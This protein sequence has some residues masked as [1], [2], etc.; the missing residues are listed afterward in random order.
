[1]MGELARALK[2]PDATIAASPVTPERL[3]ELLGLIEKRHDQRRDRQGRVR[4]DVRVR[5][6][7]RARSSRAEGLT[8][9]DDESQIVAL[10]RRRAGAAMPTRSRST[11]AGKT[12]TFGFLVGQVM[13]ATGGQGEPEARQRAA[14]SGRCEQPY[15]RSD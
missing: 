8:Q 6:G 14:A 2:E 3:A 7:G 13:K 1:M 10:D 15:D 4:E 9:I 5:P 12:A 11:A